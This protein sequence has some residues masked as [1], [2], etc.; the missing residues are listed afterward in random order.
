M[1]RSADTAKAFNRQLRATLE[2][3][4]VTAADDYRHAF[5][6]EC[7]CGEAAKITLAE[8]NEQGGA[9]IAGHRP[10]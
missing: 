3:L 7:G 2:A 10:E 9:W 1:S 8:Y 4:G 5:I 6:C